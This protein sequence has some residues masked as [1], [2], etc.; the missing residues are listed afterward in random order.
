MTL[1][2][3]AL[4]PQDN[5]AAVTVLLVVAVVDVEGRD[6]GGGG[7]G[8]GGVVAVDAVVAV[9]FSIIIVS[10]PSFVVISMA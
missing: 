1:S 6:G 4:F 8:G 5:T 2:A 7:S 9:G 3:S 10:I